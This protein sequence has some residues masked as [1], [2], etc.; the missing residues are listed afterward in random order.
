MNKKSK[1]EKLKTINRQYKK[2]VEYIKQNYDRIGILAPPG[3]KERIKNL[4]GKSAN[5]YILDLLLADLDR[6]EQ[7]AGTPEDSHG[8]T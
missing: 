2:K 1:A 3:T 8:P 4:T 7:A 6:R 5:A